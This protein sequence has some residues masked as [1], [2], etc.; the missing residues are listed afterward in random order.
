[1]IKV[2]HRKEPTFV[3]AHGHS[4]AHVRLADFEL[5]A[6]VDTDDAEHAYRLTNTIE[7]YWPDNLDPALRVAKLPPDLAG[8]RST[9][10]GD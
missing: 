1:M 4:L 9:S 2:Y 3:D 5:A 8:W 7:T 6:E 10:V